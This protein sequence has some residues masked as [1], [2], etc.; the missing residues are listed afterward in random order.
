MVEPHTPPDPVVE[1]QH[2]AIGLADAKVVHPAHGVAAQFVDDVLHGMTAVA[3]GDLPDSLLE[4]RVR[5]CRPFDRSATADAEAEERTLD[6][7]PAFALR[8]V[9]H[10]LELALDEPGDALH[11]ALRLL[12]PCHEDDE[13]VGVAGMT[14]PRR[15]ISLSSGS[16]VML[17][18]NG[19]KGPPCGTPR[20]VAS[21]VPSGSTTPARR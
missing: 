3:A 10:E 4:P 8:A 9:D 12:F 7:W 2:L 19:D 11:H 17:A 6:Q 20:G 13:V 18:S 16:R 5:F 21:R 14:C 15:S 1:L